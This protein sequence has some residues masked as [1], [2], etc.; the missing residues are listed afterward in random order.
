[1]HLG[2]LPCA[3]FGRFGLLVVE[4]VRTWACLSV[5]GEM[6]SICKIKVRLQ[7]SKV[8]LLVLVIFV[9][10][11]L[12]SSSEPRLLISLVKVSAITPRLEQMRA[13]HVAFH[14]CQNT[15]PAS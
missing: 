12:A 5:V 6:I 3:S 14:C 7:S 2:Q 13:Y 15:L 1:M 10:S 4:V 9:V 8:Y 11:A